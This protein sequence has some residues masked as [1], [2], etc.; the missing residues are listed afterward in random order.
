MGCGPWQGGGAIDREQTTQGG[1]GA[2][3]FEFPE[4]WFFGGTLREEEEGAA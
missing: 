1:G 2:V 4:R 3:A